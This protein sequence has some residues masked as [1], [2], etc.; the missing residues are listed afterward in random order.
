MICVDTLESSRAHFKVG[1]GS[2][3]LIQESKF[4]YEGRST[5]TVRTAVP[6]RFSLRVRSPEWAAP[7]RVGSAESRDGWVTLPEREWKDGERVDIA[8]NLSGRVIRG[9]FTNYS[10][11]AYAW[12]PYILALDENLNPEYS[13]NAAPQFIR[14]I[15]DRPPAL[16]ADPNRIVLQVAVRGAWD[17]SAHAVRLVPFADAGLAGK[18]YAVWLRAP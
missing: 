6:A 14:A 15:D 12:G 1:E 13:D 3:E 16:L 4:P 5:L 18:P 10:R 11:V 7:M 9:D 2:V 17:V 8:F